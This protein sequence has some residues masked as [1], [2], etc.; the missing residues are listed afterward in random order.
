[1]NM[2]IMRPSTF[3]KY[4]ES[5]QDE[6]VPKKKYLEEHSTTLLVNWPSEGPKEPES[7][8]KPTNL[9]PFLQKNGIENYSTARQLVMARLNQDNGKQASGLQQEQ[10]LIAKTA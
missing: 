7:D 8:S 4:I 3:K 1:M 2:N 9:R 5:L 6:T 10:I